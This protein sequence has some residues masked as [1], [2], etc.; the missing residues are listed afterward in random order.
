MDINALYKYL[1]LVTPNDLKVVKRDDTVDVGVDPSSMYG[2]AYADSFWI[3]DNL[4]KV[5]TIAK[6]L[7]KYIGKIF[8]KLKPYRKSG[9]WRSTYAFEIPNELREEKHGYEYSIQIPEVS[10][11]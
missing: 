5:S 10:N 1:K 2:E 3:E 8:K 11:T 7:P 9:V 6:P 4:I